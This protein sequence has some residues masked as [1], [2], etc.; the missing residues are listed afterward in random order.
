MIRKFKFTEQFTIK[1]VVDCLK[2]NSNGIFLD[3]LTIGITLFH[4]RVNIVNPFIPAFRRAA[5]SP[6]TAD[7]SGI[8]T[9]CIRLTANFAN[10]IYLRHNTI[11]FF[12]QERFESNEEH[13]FWR[14]AAYQLTHTPI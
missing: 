12:W 10:R 9:M 1:Y 4:A 6:P 2:K 3:Y 11:P 7:S 8:R 14:P 13:R 5:D